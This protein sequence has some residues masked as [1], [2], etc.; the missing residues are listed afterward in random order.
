VRESL[1]MP[2]VP[3]WASRI[4][5]ESWGVPFTLSEARL[6]YHFSLWLAPLLCLPKFPC[7]ESGSSKTWDH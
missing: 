2:L 6:Y 4:V 7:Y 3:I 5:A 1:V